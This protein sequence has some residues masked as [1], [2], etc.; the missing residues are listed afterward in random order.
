MKKLIPILL[1]IFY[2]GCD[3]SFTDVD[4]NDIPDSNVSFSKHIQPVF[5][6]KCVNCHGVGITEAG[7]DLTTWSGTVADPSIVFPGEP[8]N[9]RLVW[10]IE[11]NPVVQP[12]PP[13]GSS[14]LPLTQDQRKGVRTWVKEGAKNN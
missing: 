14:Y 9:S 8:D 4:N 5:N 6:I 11:G 3:D 10:S 12:M 7:L 13:L 2:T 1:L